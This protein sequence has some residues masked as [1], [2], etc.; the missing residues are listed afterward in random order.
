M[1]AAI[2]VIRKR[3]RE[4]SKQGGGQILSAP[5]MNRVVEATKRYHTWYSACLGLVEANMPSRL[6]ELTEKNA[7]IHF[8]DEIL[9][10]SSDSPNLE[11]RAAHRALRANLAH[12]AAIVGSIPDYL[13]TR[14]LNFGLAIATVYVNTHVAAAESLLNAGHVRA[15]GAVAGVLLEGH[16]KVLCDRQTPPVTYLPTA[17]IS[18]L[19]DALR[20]ANVYDMVQWRKV[21]Y[22]G[23]IRNQCD[24]AGMNP[25]P[26]DVRDLIAEVKKFVEL[27]A[28]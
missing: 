4:L 19:N 12:I 6:A 17:A 2:E 10:A 8:T 28:V 27:F 13:E 25:R 5:G 15:A 1:K 26:E 23:D 21:Q 9:R 24:H 3:T 22:M 7:A 14:A 18:K 11:L 20:N 16:L